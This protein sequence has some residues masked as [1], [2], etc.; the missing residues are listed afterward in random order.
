MSDSTILD[1]MERLLANQREQYERELAGLRAEIAALQSAAAPAP[2]VSDGTGGH[3]SRRSFL[4]AGLAAAGAGLALA[5]GPSLA[6]AAGGRVKLFSTT[7]TVAAK[8]TNTSWEIID[9][10]F[11]LSAHTTGRSQLIM[12]TMVAVA[13][14]GNTPA[15]GA[16]SLFIDGVA[17]AGDSPLATLPGD[18]V[19]GSTYASV[20]FNWGAKLAAGTHTFTPVYRTG[21]N[22]YSAAVGDASDPF[23]SRT[24]IPTH[25]LMVLDLP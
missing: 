13:L 1:H 3:T 22:G 16:L 12:V 5:S 15:V 10:G 14:P 7:S 21:G 24:V 25:T 2:P 11:T 6:Q 8:T 20:S 17:A 4:T 19:D 23:G 18:T 9:P